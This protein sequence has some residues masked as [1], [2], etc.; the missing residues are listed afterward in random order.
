VLVVVVVVVV[1]VVVCVCS[2]TYSIVVNTFSDTV[3][4]YTCSDHSLVAS[5]RYICTCS[6]HS[7]SFTT[8]LEALHFSFEFTA[9]SRRLQLPVLH[10]ELR[11]TC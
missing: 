1:C 2:C 6:D 3:L 8:V 4:C 11:G 10:G 7:L 9:D 5:G